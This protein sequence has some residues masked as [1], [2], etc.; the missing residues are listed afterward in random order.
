MAL[1]LCKVGTPDGRV[2]V[3]YCKARNRYELQKSLEEEGLCIFKVRRA[4]FS[5]T[6]FTD[7]RKKRWSQHRFL[8]FNQELLVLL[9]SG[10]PII[11]ILDSLVQEKDSSATKAVLR[12]VKTAVQGGN[13]L[14]EAFSAYPEFFSSLYVATVASGEKTGDLPQTVSRFLAYQKR[15]A[16]LRERLKSAAFYP[17]FLL[18]A[19]V[20]VL[21]FMIFF[22]IP[23][24]M[25]IFADA[26][27]ALPLLTRVVLAGASLAA[28][29]WPFV[30]V[31]LVLLFW[32]LR[33]F[34]QTPKG[35]L[36]LDKAILK[37]P[38][39]GHLFRLSGLVNFCRTTATI[40]ASGL[41][42]VEAMNLACAVLNN[43]ILQQ[44]VTNVVISVNEGDTLGNALQRNQIF[45]LVAVRM[46]GT[47]EKTG[48]LGPM[49]EEVSD[50]YEAEIDNSLE[51][52]ASLA[53][54]LILLFVG[55]V[56]GGIVVAIYLP[57]FQ[58]AGT[59]R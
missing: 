53:E 50:Y 11:E 3:R 57:I 24:F 23:S 48:T 6:F 30:L 4:L 34:I 36:L 47:G 31:F 12:D 27:V 46:I 17:L 56:I 29:G 9:R 13:S 26:Q 38:G 32:M 28:H 54:P 55:F 59:V 7:R 10:M 51:R 5:L 35:R 14:S 15:L 43:R 39:I 18:A 21:L 52:L 2:I 37:T 58:L 49:F 45:P 8:L 42:L 19:T 20:A 16:R 44:G 41:P 40:L 25:Q 1:F 33:R 22:V